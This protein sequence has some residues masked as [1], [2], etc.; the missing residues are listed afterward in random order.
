MKNTRK[1]LGWVSLITGLFNIVYIVYAMNYEVS[2]FLSSVAPIFASVFA[3]SLT[4]LVLEKNYTGSFK[5]Y[6]IV[7]FV[8]FLC[9][10]FLAIMV[11]KESFVVNKEVHRQIMAFVSGI[12]L[13]AWL[14]YLA[15]R[16]KNKEDQQ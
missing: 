12:A 15:L 9:L 13:S 6:G 8:S 11:D 10:S 1:I 3:A 5:I 7:I 16:R 14:T 2:A 4:F